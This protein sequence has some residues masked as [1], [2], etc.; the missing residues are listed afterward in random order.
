MK[1]SVLNQLCALIYLMTGRQCE[2]MFG[3]LGKEKSNILKHKYCKKS[4]GEQIG[5]RN[6]FSIEHI[7]IIDNA[8]CSCCC[9]YKWFMCAEIGNVLFQGC[10][11]W[12]KI[13]WVK[14]C[15]VYSGICLCL[16]C[17]TVWKCFCIAPQDMNNFYFLKNCVID[18]NTCVS[19][20]LILQI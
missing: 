1:Q 16:W 3:N 12:K 20:W 5:G 9:T 7:W 6:I 14:C 8:G 2:A 18:G 11:E 17:S 4:M 15:R 19:I 13:V 10:A